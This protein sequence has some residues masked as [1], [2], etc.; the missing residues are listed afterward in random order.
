MNKIQQLKLLFEKSRE[1]LLRLMVYKFRTSE[2]D[3]EDIVQDAFINI[4]S[5]EQLKRMDNP[6]A[7]L[8]QTASNLA[9]NRIKRKKYHTRYVQ[10]QDITKS[11]ELSPERF[12]IAASDCERLQKALE[13]LPEKCRH[14]FMLSR[15][16]G[17]SY[18]A[19]SEHLGIAESTVEKHIIKTLRFLRDE[20]KEG[21]AT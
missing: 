19:I 8:Y 16:N 3:A 6:K 5:A 15:A 12:A 10:E 14:T 13:R 1:D 21:S 9:L 20:L 4:L 11:D 2:S 17:M 7:Y 18:R